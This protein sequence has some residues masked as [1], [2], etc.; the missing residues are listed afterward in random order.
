MMG[1]ILRN[2]AFYHNDNGFIRVFLFRSRRVRWSSV[3]EIATDSTGGPEVRLRSGKTFTVPSK[4]EGLAPF[5][6]AAEARG[7]PLVKLYPDS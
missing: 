3:L 5:L 4:F 1:L 6:R 7:V 2:Y